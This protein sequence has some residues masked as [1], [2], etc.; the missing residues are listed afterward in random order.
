M[1]DR[2]IVRAVLFSAAIQVTLKTHESFGKVPGV[3]ITKK[4]FEQHIIKE[5]GEM[6]D[7]MVDAANLHDEDCSCRKDE[8]EEE[9]EKNTEPFKLST[10][11][12]EQ[13]EK[14]FKELADAVGGKAVVGGECRRCGERVMGHENM[15]AHIKAHK[16]K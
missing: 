6:I 5:A 7:D 10:E 14:V 9:G 15:I 2:N 1:D 8:D 12:M 11:T 13:I 3:P 16:E 4:E